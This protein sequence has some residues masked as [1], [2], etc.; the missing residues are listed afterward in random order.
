[1]LAMARG[2]YV[3]F[4]GGVNGRRPRSF[5]PCV[6]TGKV[7]LAPPGM[8]SAAIPIYGPITGM[9]RRTPASVPIM[10]PKSIQMP[11]PS[12]T[13]PTK[14]HLDKI[15]RIPA[16]NANVPFHFLRS[17]KKVR[18]FA[19]PMRAVMPIRR[20]MLPMDRRARSKKKKMP[21]V[22]KSAPAVVKAA[23]TSVCLLALFTCR[24]MNTPPCYLSWRIGELVTAGDSCN[25]RD[26]G[27]EDV[28]CESDNHIVGIL[29]FTLL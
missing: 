5:S 3:V 11:Y 16:A 6:Y 22:R 2:F 23:P 18:V 1:M 24:D 17:A 15:N 21:S 10:P 9:L 4:Q 14:A 8:R 12:T 20:R 25:G 26:K 28:L 13:N 29:T 19:G 27:W 7:S